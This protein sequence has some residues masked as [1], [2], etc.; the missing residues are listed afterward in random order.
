MFSQFSF[1][2]PSI[3]DLFTSLSTDGDAIKIHSVEIHDVETA[4]KKPA[5]ALKHLLKLNHVTYSILYHNDRFHNH[6]PHLLSSAYLF[7]SDATHLSRLYEMEEKVLE[8]WRDSPEEIAVD[9]WREYLGKPEYQRAYLDFFEDELVHHSYD[10]RK[11]VEMY[12]YSGDK[13]L[14]NNVVAGLGHP[15]IHLGYA[16]E[17]SSR[18]VAIESLAMTATCYNYLHKYID[19]HS[20]LETPPTY[21]TSSSLEILHKIRTDKRFDNLFEE[22]GGDNLEIVFKDHEDAILEHWRAWAI[23][24]DPVKQLEVSQ[25]DTAA[26]FVAA[27]TEK[28]DFFLVHLLTTSHAIRILLPFV[29]SRF[30]VSLVRQWWLIVVGVYVAQL[31]PKIEPDAIRYYDVKGRNWDWIGGQAINGKWAEETHFI[32]ALRALKEAAKTWGD[33]DE[34]YI[35]AAV[36]LVDDFKGFGGFGEQAA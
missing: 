9:D 35:K 3:Q 25:K 7:G 13:P 8:P 17:M 1:S 30:H 24:P 22:P 5:R 21:Q 29:P 23:T 36:K 27:D 12:L 26:I 32:K 11:V 28:H 16:Y 4:K 15:L 20:Y 6:M 34:Y 18:D 2:V 10:W 19:D 14:I 31:R 33:S